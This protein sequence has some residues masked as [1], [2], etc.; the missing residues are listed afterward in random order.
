MAVPLDAID[1]RL[2]GTFPAQVVQRH[3]ET[4]AGSAVLSLPERVATDSLAVIAIG[5]GVD[6]DSAAVP[7]VLFA[8]RAVRRRGA[9]F[10][11]LATIVGRATSVARGDSNVDRV[12]RAA[13]RVDQP[14]HRGRIR[15]RSSNSRS[16]PTITV[17]TPW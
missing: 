15:A 16:I 3:A 10:V 1:V 11:V 5:S 9:I 8:M 17:S 13:D 2:A 12:A 4:I 6:R 14:G 7:N